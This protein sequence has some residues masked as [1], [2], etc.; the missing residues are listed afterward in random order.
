MPFATR[1][2]TIKKPQ[3][4]STLLYVLM[5]FYVKPPYFLHIISEKL[6]HKD[7]NVPQRIEKYATQNIFLLP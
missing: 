2:L 6:I 1:T 4:Y 5:S 3:F 7:S